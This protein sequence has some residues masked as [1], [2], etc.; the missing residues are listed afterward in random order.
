MRVDELH[1]RALTLPHPDGADVDWKALLDEPPEVV[2]FTVASAEKRPFYYGLERSIW[3]H[4]APT[5]Y[6]YLGRIEQHYRRHYDIYV[7]ED[8]DMPPLPPDIVLNT[9]G[10]LPRTTISVATE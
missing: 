10:Q 3:K 7:R 2:A 4:L 6:V 9:V 8:V 1:P 5:R